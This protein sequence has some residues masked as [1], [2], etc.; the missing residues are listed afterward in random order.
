[1]EQILCRYL[2]RWFSYEPNTAKQHSSLILIYC[3]IF[4]S[5]KF[6]A[7]ITEHMDMSL[8][9]ALLKTSGK[10]IILQEVRINLVFLCHHYIIRRC[11]KGKLSEYICLGHIGLIKRRRHHVDAP[12]YLFNVPFFK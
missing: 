4:T 8:R 9:K 7:N 1:M 10:L 2:V 6:N 11:L 5:V 12:C 3:L